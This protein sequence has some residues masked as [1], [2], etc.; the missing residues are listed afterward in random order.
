M[1]AA[2]E[3][4]FKAAGKYSRVFVVKHDVH[5]VES[6]AFFGC[7]PIALVPLRLRQVLED[8]ELAPVAEVVL[9]LPEALG[10][11]ALF[12]NATLL[13]EPV[14]WNA[15]VELSVIVG[16]ER[17]PASL[18]LFRVSEFNALITLA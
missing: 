10:S 9:V 14:N 18:D 3:R 11:N 15:R 4:I 1:N 16:L 8:S 5:T 13:L 2:L 6:A 7:F 12:G 17:Q